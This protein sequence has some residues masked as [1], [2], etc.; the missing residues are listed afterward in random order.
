[1]SGRQTSNKQNGGRGVPHSGRV[2]NT[3]RGNGQFRPPSTPLLKNHRM[4]I[5]PQLAFLLLLMTCLDALQPRQRH[6]RIR[7]REFLPPLATTP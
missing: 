1:M 7:H 2:P 3:G 5:T 6:R 4:V